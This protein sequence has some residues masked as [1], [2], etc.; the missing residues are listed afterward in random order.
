[1][2]DM[3]Y[4]TEELAAKQKEYKGDKAIGDMPKYPYGLSLYLNSD[5]IKKLGMET[6]TVGQK[7]TIT[8]VAEVNGFSSHKQADGDTESTANIQITAM[9]VSP[10]A[11]DK[12][13]AQE[14][15][16]GKTKE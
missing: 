10:A 2:K 4:T 16:Y 9:E 8:A 5:I 12:A 6:P 7:I 1:M 3:A 15:L 13:Q 11:V 14:T